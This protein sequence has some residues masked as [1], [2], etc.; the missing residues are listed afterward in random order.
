MA[1]GAITA[2]TAGSSLPPM[3]ATSDQPDADYLHYG[4]WLMRT[5]DAD[6]VLTYNE[7]ETFADSSVDPSGSV[8]QSPAAQPMKA[9]PR[10]CT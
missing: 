9:V 1:M 10:A 8:M 3:G 6:G 2:L 4:F 7:V 5:T